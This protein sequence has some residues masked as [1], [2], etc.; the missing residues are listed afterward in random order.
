[1]PKVSVIVPV[2]NVEKYLSKCL[3]SILNQT[4]SDIEIICVNDG[5][6]DNSRKILEEYKQKDSRIKIIDKENGGL[7]SARNAGLKIAQGEFISFIDSDD[8]IES[9]M[10]EKLY[11]NITQMNSDISICAVSL[12]NE[13]KQEFDNSNPYFSLGFFNNTFDNKSFSYR[14]TLPFI[15]DVCVMAWNK[16]YRKSFLDKCNAKFPDGKIFEDGPFFFS[17]FFKTDRVSIVREPLYF[18]R[19]N[20]K[21]SI[22]QKADKNFIDIIDIVELMYNSIKEIPEFSYVKDLFYLRKVH[23]IVYRYQLINPIYRKLFAKKLKTK[24]FL[25][26]YSIFNIDYIDEK[27]PYTYKNLIKIE[28]DKNYKK[29]WKN[30]FRK[31]F[32]YKIIQI[33]YFD[34]DCYTFKYKKFI[35]KFKKRKNICDIWYKNDKIYFVLFNHIKFNIKFEFSDLEKQN[36]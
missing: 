18:Y 13:Q 28:H 7:S 29:Y 10:L 6:Q 2:Y 32:M 14:E 12:Y 26:N 17:I 36:K 31:K 9:K 24:E 15:M 5:T 8:W 3:E 11:H 25:F 33:L 21:G 20:R 35:L 23:D 19:I 34:N 30:R 4:F 27:D 16:L 1:M 22:V